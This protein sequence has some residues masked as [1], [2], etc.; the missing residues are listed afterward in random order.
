MSTIRWKLEDIAIHCQNGYCFNIRLICKK[1]YQ[2]S[3]NKGNNINLL[4]MMK[5]KLIMMVKNF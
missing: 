3:D 1:I 5:I 4:L 2:N